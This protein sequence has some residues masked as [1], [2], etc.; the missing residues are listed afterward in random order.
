MYEK[1]LVHIR[2]ELARIREE[3]KANLEAIEELENVIGQLGQA[4][5]RGVIGKDLEDFA[6]KNNISLRA[7]GNQTAPRRPAISGSPD[8]IS[9]PRS[10]ATPVSRP[11]IKN[12][13]IRQ[14]ADIYGK[15]SDATKKSISTAR[16]TMART[17]TGASANI[18]A[19]VGE[20]NELQQ[21]GSFEQRTQ[22]DAFIKKYEMCGF[23]CQNF[24]RRLNH[25]EDAPIFAD[26]E[27]IADSQL[28]GFRPAGAGVYLAVPNKY[29]GYN[30]IMHTTG[31]LGEIFESNFQSGMTYKKIEVRM[32]ATF[33]RANGRWKLNAKGRIMLS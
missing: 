23:S 19:F 27:S 33:T 20:Y 15:T 22:R 12:A 5:T 24:E 25:I 13:P 6:A 21:R 26:N 9:K 16:P 18:N 2:R 11:T 29:K 8:N 1:L 4:E 3:A 10:N 28:W 7:L 30:E 17:T 14:N 31:A 32:P